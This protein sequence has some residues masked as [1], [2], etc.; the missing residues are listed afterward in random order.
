MQPE[1]AEVQ[2]SRNYKAQRKSDAIGR[3]M[4]FSYRAVFFFF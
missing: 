1:A 4:H 3:V 2:I